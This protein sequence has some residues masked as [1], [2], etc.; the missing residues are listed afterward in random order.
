MQYEYDYNK[1]DF[2]CYSKT[3]TAGTN[4]YFIVKSTF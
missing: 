1:G 3:E 2:L 4:N